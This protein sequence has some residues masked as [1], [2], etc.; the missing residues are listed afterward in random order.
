MN[1]YQSYILPIILFCLSFCWVSGFAQQKDG[2]TP[3]HFNVSVESNIGVYVKDSELKI[4]EQDRKF[5]TNTFVNLGYGVGNFRMGAQFDVFEPALLGFPSELKGSRLMQGF[6]SYLSPKVEATLGSFYEQFG[7]GLLLRTYEDRALGINTALMG[8]SLRLRPFDWLSIKTF[9]G[10]PRKHMRYVHSRV[11]GLDAEVSLSHLLPDDVVNTLSVGGAWILRDDHSKLEYEHL[12]P[13]RSVNGFSGRG[14]LSKGVLTLSGEYTYKG[15]NMIHDGTNLAP[16]GQAL[17]FNAGLD[18]E[19][20]GI[21][22]QFRSI[23]NMSLGIDDLTDT[24]SVFL[25]YIPS[26]TKLQ[27]YALLSLYPH[28]AS[29]SLGGGEIGGQVDVFGSIPL[30]SNDRYPLSFNLNASYFKKLVAKD[31]PGQYKF[32]DMSG[33]LS[34]A[35]VGLE[36]EKKWNKALKTVMVMDWQQSME[37]SRLGHGKMKMNTGVLVTDILYKITRKNSLRMELQHAWSDSKDDQRWIMGLLEWGLS[38]YWVFYVSDMYNYESAGK[39][40]HYFSA[41]ANFTWKSL[42]VGASFGRNREGLQCSGGVCRYVPEYTGFMI[43]ISST[44]LLDIIF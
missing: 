35:E 23:E 40:I 20:L 1:L 15:N 39:K 12:K 10:L 19:G 33:E 41:G 38:P 26:L 32:L 17:L 27:K 25:N 22:S 13:P 34:F 42:R 30:N 16:K 43:N 2:Q 44:N 36:L 21:T 4:P 24:E 28:S 11:Y 9:A 5:R 18:F 37:F 29:K 14:Q 6:A 31:T 8:V 3:S 7:S